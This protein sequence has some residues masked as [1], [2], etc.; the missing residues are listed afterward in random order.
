MRYWTYMPDGTLWAPPAGINQ[1]FRAQIE[2]KFPGYQDTPPPTTPALVY[3]QVREYRDRYPNIAFVPM[4]SGAGPLPILMGG[5][6]AQSS[7]RGGGGPGARGGG[8]NQDPI[9][10]KFVHDY[11]AS[12]LMKMNPVDGWVADP[13]AN[14]VLAGGAAEPILIDSLSG[15]E[16]TF[17]AALPA[18]TYHAVWFDPRTGTPHDAISVSGAAGTSLT[19]PD[20]R[21][22]LLLLTPQTN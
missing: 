1:A 11:L 17:A 20:T 9:I 21:E 10:D 8:P 22:W 13:T 16:I 14:W 5:G 2:A 4:E 7:L 12:D 15:A 19:K 18:R 6:A 3:K